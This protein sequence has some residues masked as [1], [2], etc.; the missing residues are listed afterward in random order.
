VAT[1]VF[2]LTPLS[3]YQSACQLADNWRMNTLPGLLQ[4]RSG[5]FS[6][7]H[8]TQINGTNQRFF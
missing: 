2:Y 8:K 4:H 1:K 5:E 7:L 3:A 6:T